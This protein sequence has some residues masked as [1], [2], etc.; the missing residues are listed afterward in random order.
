VNQN[1]LS[2]DFDF[3]SVDQSMALPDLDSNSN[4]VANDLSSFYYP[5]NTQIR[6]LQGS[7]S[8]TV[9]KVSPVS[10]ASQSA[11]LNVNVMATEDIDGGLS[12]PVRL[13]AEAAEE[14]TTGSSTWDRS[15]VDQP[16][17]SKVL[18]PPQYHLPDT[19]QTILMEGII[20]SRVQYLQHDTEYLAQGLE[21][22]LSDTAHSALTESD[23]RF[24]TPSR[25]DTKR[26]IG[27]EYDPIA[28][29]LVSPREVKAFF[30]AFF[31]K[32]HPV[33]P[34]L[35]P[36]LHTSECEFGSCL[37]PVLISH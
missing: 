12:N 13:L 20:D 8:S 3:Y 17:S 18:L 28:L 27:S 21:S 34:V 2:T 6:P 11:N 33:L 19:L 35:D 32:L 36:T 22:L 9:P 29:A 23:K 24:F 7:G 4:D 15:A 30:S 14:S 37:R 5:Q 31:A 25:K 26:D 16:V 1:E 10:L